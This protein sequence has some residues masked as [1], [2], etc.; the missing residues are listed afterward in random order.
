MLSVP[1]NIISVL[2]AA[3]SIVILL[4]DV[5]ILTAASPVDMSSAAILE[6]VYVLSAENEQL[7]S[8]YHRHSRL[9]GQRQ[10]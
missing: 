3:A 8:L 10:R 7:V 5:V 9:S 1:L 2:S 4:D 6:L